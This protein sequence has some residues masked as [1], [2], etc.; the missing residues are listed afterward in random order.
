MGTTSNYSWPYPEATGLVKDGWEDI[1][2]LATAIDTTASTTF[3]SNLVKINSTSFSAVSSQSINNVFSSTY[4]KYVVLAYF[5]QS[6]NTAE[7]RSRLRVSGADN[8]TTN[9]NASGLTLFSSGSSTGNAGEGI[10]Y[11]GQYGISNECYYIMNFTQPFQTAN[12]LVSIDASL[13]QTGTGRKSNRGI[14]AGT[15]AATTSFDGFTIYPS[16]GT[17]TGKITVFGIKE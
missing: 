16:T 5:S 10:T 11:F 13:Y 14:Y 2:D 7:I 6:S 12:T 4:D 15:F 3:T 1:K 17:I 9:Y 8:T